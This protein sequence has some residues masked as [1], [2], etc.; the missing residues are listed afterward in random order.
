VAFFNQL[1]SVL[2]L[3]IAAVFTSKWRGVE[4]GWYVILAGA[5]FIPFMRVG[6]SEDAHNLALLFG[7]ASLWLMECYAGHRKTGYLVASVVTLVV[8]LWSRQ[9]LFP[10]APFVL[11]WGMSRIGLRNLRPA[12]YGASAVIVLF[13]TVKIAS[14]ISG[15]S[16]L[17]GLMHRILSNRDILWAIMTGHP[18][19][20]L[21]GFGTLSAILI[22][23]G[24]FAALQRRASSG[25]IVVITFGL[26]FAFT[27]VSGFNGSMGQWGFRLP[28]FWLGI[29]LA[30]MGA[31]SVLSFCT[32]R[33]RTEFER[34]PRIALPLLLLVLPMFSLQ[35]AVLGKVRPQQAEVD[36]VSSWLGELPSKAR[37]VKRA[38]PNYPIRA[39]GKSVS[40]VQT[41]PINDGSSFFYVGLECFGYRLHE[42]MELEGT[43]HINRGTREYQ[44]KVMKTGERLWKHGLEAALPLRSE[45]VNVPKT[46]E[47]IASRSISSVMHEFPFHYALPITLKLYR[48]Q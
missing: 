45:C 38:P 37:F 42:I 35:W 20:D 27:L 14:F 26:F 6:A 40:I 30:A 9:T 48:L 46:A 13:T 21:K 16:G 4:T 32:R 7:F 11:V 36:F 22:P 25:F 28:V 41:V 44:T 12:F 2:S 31:S 8:M 43:N 15:Q 18:L 5:F 39:V 34:I 24:V 19:L 10:W 1:A 17:P 47:L 3:F 23:V 33:L 29:I